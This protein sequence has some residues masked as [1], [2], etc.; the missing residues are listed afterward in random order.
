[1]EQGIVFDIASKA[2]KASKEIA[3]LSGIEK[4]SILRDM[5]GSLRENMDGLQEANRMDLDAAAKNILSSAMIDRLRLDEGAIEKMALALEEIAGIPDPTGGIMG[6][7]RRPNGLLV[8]KM[9]IPLGVVGMIYE[10]RP[11]V[12]ADVAGLC[13][14]SGNAVVLRG[15]S[16]AF[17]SNRAI[18][19]I[20]KQVLVLHG[21]QPDAIGFIP[22]TG[23]KAVMEMIVLDDYIDV[24]IPRGGE[25]LIRIVAENSRIPVLKHYK[26]VC[27]I[28]VD[29]AADLDMAYNICMNAKVQRPGVCNAMETL[30]VDKEIAQ[31]FL[32]EM[33]R[34][35][36]SAGVDLRGC[37]R[38]CAILDNIT[39]AEPQDWDKEY[40]DLVLA[41]RIV[42]NMEQAM[43]HIDRYG[44]DHT[45][46]IITQD[47][48]K[49]MVF[50]RRVRSSTVM[51]NA[52]TRFA[53]GGEF[54]LGAEVGISTSRIHAYGPM[55]VEGLT[56][57][58]F[59][60]FGDGQIRE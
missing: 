11:N 35:F 4:D 46:S 39:K 12:T 3:G 6:M 9:R 60:C 42:D 27:H 25:G 45:E 58:K 48:T 22:V 16:E 17:N 1:M 21:V 5:A 20:L 55:G 38:T 34:R 57:E 52:S 10:S 40:L 36:V 53:D 18:A 37:E 13:I 51:V 41:V 44:S 7:Q 33:A 54:G 8:G 2:A 30:L 14:K 47:Y 29:A 24:I 43:D 31:A 28:F 59:V 56:I 32:P 19:D 49:T 15:G 23:H 26:G 50:L